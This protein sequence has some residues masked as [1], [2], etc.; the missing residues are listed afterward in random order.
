MGRLQL[1]EVVGMLQDWHR[2][3]THPCYVCASW[4]VVCTQ[5]PKGLVAEANAPAELP[6][7]RL[8]LMEVVD[9]LL[10]IGRARAALHGPESEPVADVHFVAA[11][12]LIQVRHVMC[13]QSR[14]QDMGLLS[15][16]WPCLLA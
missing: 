2:A 6:V 14:G 9:M 7:G 3:H 16:A 8:Q 13:A 12:A 15:H 4:R 10:D 11:L 1:A 5:T